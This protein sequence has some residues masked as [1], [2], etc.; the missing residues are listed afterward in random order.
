MGLGSAEIS[1]RF[2]RMVMKKPTAMGFLRQQLAGLPVAQ[3]TARPTAVSRQSQ[4]GEPKFSA[5]R[6]AWLV[7]PDH[8]VIVANFCDGNPSAG[9][10]LR[11]AGNVGILL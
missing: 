2:S 3:P 9:H 11:I 8:A 4:P 5:I 10:E 1:H 7:L 6:R